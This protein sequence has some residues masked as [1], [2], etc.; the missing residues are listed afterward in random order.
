MAIIFKFIFLEVI[1]S[2]YMCKTLVTLLPVPVLV[3]CDLVLV[4]RH[5]W[6]KNMYILRAIRTT[7]RAT[8][9]ESAAPKAAIKHPH[10]AQ[11]VPQLPAPALLCRHCIALPS[12]VI[13]IITACTGTTILIATPPTIAACIRSCIHVRRVEPVAIVL[14]KVVDKF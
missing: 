3:P 10:R 9:Y 6:H 11:W 4:C 2:L 14:C 7:W 1:I 5:S 12:R 13:F 8:F